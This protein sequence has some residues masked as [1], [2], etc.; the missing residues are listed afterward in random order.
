MAK[1]PLRKSKGTWVRSSSGKIPECAQAALRQRLALHAATPQYAGRCREVVVR[2]RGLYAYVD[3]FPVKDDIPPDASA[4]EIERIKATPI[5]LF[6]LG[7]VGDPNRWAFAF[8][9]YSTESY[10]PSLAMSCSF[11]ATPEEAFDTGAVYLTA[12]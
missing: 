11:Q 10:E 9:K 8:F 7:Y 1:T 12:Y 3:A 5:R 2:F 4:E 6:R